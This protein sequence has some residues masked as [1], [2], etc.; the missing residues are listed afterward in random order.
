MYL[1][2]DDDKEVENV[3]AVAQIRVGINE[4]AAS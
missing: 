2:K 1:P 3:P 4:E